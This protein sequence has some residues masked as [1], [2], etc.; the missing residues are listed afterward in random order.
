MNVILEGKEF[1]IS[2]VDEADKCPVPL[3][4]LIRSITTHVQHVGPKTFGLFLQ[5]S[6]PISKLWL[7]KIGGSAGFLQGNRFA[8]DDRCRSNGNDG[9]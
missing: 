8:S 3:A 2:G 6:V 9:S 7:T 5:G 4:K 1:L